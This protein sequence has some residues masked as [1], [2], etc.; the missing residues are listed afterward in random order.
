MTKSTPSGVGLLQTMKQL[1]R[2]SI[3]KNIIISTKKTERMNHGLSN[4]TTAIIILCLL[5]VVLFMPF[6]TDAEGYE[7]SN[8]YG[9]VATVSKTVII[10][11]DI[12]Y[13][14]KTEE[15]YGSA[16]ATVAVALVSLINDAI[17]R[18]VA[19]KH[20]VAVTQE[21]ITSY[22][23]YVDKNTKLPKIL[24]K[25]KCVF[26][27]DESSYEQI[28]LAPKILKR[29]LRYFFS[30]NHELQMSERT[31]IEKAHN[32]VASRKT[33]QETAEE[34]GV[35]YS[36]FEIGDEGVSIPPELQKYMPQ[37]EKIPQDPLV[38]ILETLSIGEIYKNIVEDDYSYR[39]VRLKG[40]DGN[41]YS[42]EA[43]TVK[44]NPFNVW[45]K[46]QAAY[47]QIEILDKQLQR[48]I[49]SKYPN[50]W[51]VKKWREKCEPGGG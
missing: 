5:L 24:H 43:L 7:S 42:V 48:E 45:F 27:K 49:A 11:R 13:R 38:S 20:G 8:E 36:S 17:E 3:C 47:I 16:R 2:N 29:K 31:L 46:D 23:K 32:L 30:R 37:D 12:S 18:E 41:K 6:L 39:A 22:R 4:S 14:I 33:F 44:K 9:V 34:M 51:W 21:E 50:V 28:Y 26:G 1:S 15:A 40:R 25:V 19:L 10:L 35:E